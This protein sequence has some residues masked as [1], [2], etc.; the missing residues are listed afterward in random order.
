[1]DEIPRG[2]DAEVWWRRFSGGRAIFWVIVSAL[3]VA[4]GWINSVAFVA[5]CS[6]YANITG[7]IGAWRADVNPQLDVLQEQLDRVERLLLQLVEA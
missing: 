2:V 1:M 4:L 5:G 7:D 3:A 6:L